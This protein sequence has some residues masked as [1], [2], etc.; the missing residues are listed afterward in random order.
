[1]SEVP[2]K[3]V[4]GTARVL[5]FINRH[6]PLEF[7]QGMRGIGLERDGELIAGIIYEG[8]NYQSIWAHIAAEPGSQWLN[9]EYLRFCCN[10]PYE[11]CNVKFVLGYM[12][13]TNTHALRFAKHLGFEEETRIR[14]AAT[15]GGDIL[16]LKMR[17]ENCRYAKAGV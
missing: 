4:F 6:R 5:E 12:D 16:I 2:S 3:I 14:E 8:W 9:K 17:K 11:I 1:L 7:I 13:A 10:Y 15:E